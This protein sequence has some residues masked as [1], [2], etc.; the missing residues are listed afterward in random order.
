MG[1]EGV[2]GA[3]GSQQGGCPLVQGKMVCFI[4]SLQS[5]GALRTRQ[6]G[7]QLHFLPHLS[8]ENTSSPS[9]CSNHMGSVFSAPLTPFQLC[10]LPVPRLCVSPK[11]RSSPASPSSVLIPVP[12]TPPAR[13][14]PLGRPVTHLRGVSSTPVRNADSRALPWTCSVGNSAQK[15]VF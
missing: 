15:S 7:P 2:G 8:K 4:Y 13:S 3:Q 6:S 14:L 5:S 9:G 12:C 1:W 10:L 11:A